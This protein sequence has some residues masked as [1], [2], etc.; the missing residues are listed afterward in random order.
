[1]EVDAVYSK[2]NKSSG[3]G[4]KSKSKT[5]K[6]KGSKTDN[7]KPKGGKDKGKAKTDKGK[8]GGNNADYID[9]ECGYCKKWGH[10]RAD[11]RKRKADEASSNQPQHQRQWQQ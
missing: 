7:N 4:W 5:D 6:G 11:C 9:G 2:T 1:M 10:K 3:E 8:S